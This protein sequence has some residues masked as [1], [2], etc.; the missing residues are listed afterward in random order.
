MV[1]SLIRSSKNKTIED[2]LDSF[3]KSASDGNLENYF[4]CFYNE[5]SRFL[6]TDEKEN[7]T[8]SEF[9]DYSFKYFDGTPAWIYIP[10]SGSRKIEIFPSNDKP[11]FATFD[12]LL[13]SK[14]F[15]ITCRGSGTLIFFSGYWYIC[16]YHLSFPIP[17]EIAKNLTKSIADYSQAK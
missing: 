4:G 1:E 5:N 6:G 9:Y 3:N 13:S 7:W 8:V 10:I 16:A 17:N 2:L 14:S 11:N 15:N 12:E